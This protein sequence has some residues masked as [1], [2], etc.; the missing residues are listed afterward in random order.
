M[1]NPLKIF[2]KKTKVRYTP[3]GIP[4]IKFLHTESI[5]V[6]G[7]VG[8]DNPPKKTGRS[9]TFVIDKIYTVTRA[10]NGL[11]AVEVE[12]GEGLLLPEDCTLV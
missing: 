10:V 12:G 7:S 9:V 1:I 11:I 5:F 4:N 8:V 3:K 6:K 2:K